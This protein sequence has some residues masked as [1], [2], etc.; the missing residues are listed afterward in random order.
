M[1][2]EETSPT[3]GYSDR[4]FVSSAGHPSPEERRLTRRE[5]RLTGRDPIEHALDKKS[6]T[7]SRA[8]SSS[9]SSGAGPRTPCSISSQISSL[10]WDGAYA[11]PTYSS[12]RR[13]DADLAN[14]ELESTFDVPP[15]PSCSST[16]SLT[17]LHGITLLDR[18]L[19]QRL[20]DSNEKAAN[21]RA[22]SEINDSVFEPDGASTPTPNP[23]TL[24]GTGSEDTVIEVQ[25]RPEP[26]DT[27]SDKANSTNDQS[28]EAKSDK[29]DSSAEHFTEAESE[30]TDSSADKTKFSKYLF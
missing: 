6:R 9:Q 1:N 28:V 14:L 8:R 16:N 23:S 22:G 26:V 29:T 18:A 2:S 3:I 10:E 21:G 17:G 7:I 27:S 20:L 4:R 24:T 30:K 5:R 12:T 11:S 15:K 13:L 19:K 25:P